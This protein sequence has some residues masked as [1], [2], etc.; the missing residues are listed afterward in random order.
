M[1]G[2]IKELKSVL[3]SAEIVNL[4]ISDFVTRSAK[5]VGAKISVDL[6]SGIEK[7]LEEADAREL[8]ESIAMRVKI[9]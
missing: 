5:L 8:L 3:K 1:Y 4:V 6:Y 7:N 9:I 2:S